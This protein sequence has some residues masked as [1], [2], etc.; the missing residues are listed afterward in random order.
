M[1]YTFSPTYNLLDPEVLA[2]PYPL[3]QRL[4][5]EAPVY[6]HEGENAWLISRYNDVTKLLRDPRFTAVPL[7]VEWE[8]RRRL[9]KVLSDI[10]QF[11][12]PPCHTHIRGLVEK[13]FFPLF[14]KIRE[15]SQEILD[16]LLDNFQESG[17]IDLIRDL[18]EPFAFATITEL[19]GVSFDDRA[20]FRQWYESFVRFAVITS[21]SPT[22]EEEDQQILE[23]MQA[24]TEYVRK[25]VKQRSQ[26]PKDDVITAL[27]YAEVEDEKLSEQAIIVN[28]MQMTFGGF[29][30]TV[31]GVGIALLLLL[32]YPDEMQKLQDNPTLIHSA[33][34][35]CLR[36]ETF[37]QW[38]KRRATENIELHGHLIHKNQ[39]VLF[40]LGSANH[41]ETRFPEPDRFD[42]SRTDNQHVSFSFGPH[43]CIG[44]SFSRMMMQIVINTI[45]YRLRDMRLKTDGLE[46][47]LSPS[48][49][50]PVSLPVTFE[51]S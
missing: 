42:I 45:I 21:H 28:C 47:N 23:H 37:T 25:I 41:D 51:P 26:E 15:R 34:E 6:W 38:V 9:M 50:V 11:E 5:S 33:L 43:T 44:A 3:Y 31:C 16:S 4:R 10:M 39:I 17:N 22:T 35:E 12:D 40:G 46:W 8:S 13:A 27:I 14:P 32:R 2:N 30:P 36:Y 1:A 19:M 48:F 20:Q 18:A 7:D 29:I 49:R 24:M